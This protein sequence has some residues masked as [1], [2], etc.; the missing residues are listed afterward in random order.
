MTEGLMPEAVLAALKPEAVVP[1]MLVLAHESAPTR[2]TLCA[3]AGGFEA[4][5]ITLT[6]GVYLGQGDQVPE[7]LAAQLA[8]VL[9]RKSTRLNSSHLVISYAVFCLKKKNDRHRVQVVGGEPLEQQVVRVQNDL[10]H[11]QHVRDEAVG[12]LAPAH[13]LGPAFGADHLF[14]PC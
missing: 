4:A 12:R 8:Q 10:R 9:D 1:A 6:E 2:T 11:V 3:G 5:F 7:Q 14:I 13:R